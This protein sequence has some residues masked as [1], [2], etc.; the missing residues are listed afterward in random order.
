MANLVPFPSGHTALGYI[1]LLFGSRRALETLLAGLMK[2]LA[3]LGKLCS[4]QQ[5]PV[6][7]Q[8]EAGA[9]SASV[10]IRLTAFPRPPYVTLNEPPASLGFRVL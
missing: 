1:R 3:M 7:S 5:S 2:F 6:N 10:E 9:L 4:Q 8:Q